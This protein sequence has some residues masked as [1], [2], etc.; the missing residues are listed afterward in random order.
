LAFR[1]ELADFFEEASSA[2]VDPPPPAQTLANWICG[3][4]VSRLPDGGSPRDC[5]ASPA[6]VAALVGLVSASR[7][8][9]GAGRTVLDRLVASGGD[10]VAIVEAEGLAAIDSSDEL[11][12]LVAAALQAHPEAAENVRAGNPKAIGPLVAH[13]MRESSGR[14]DGGAVT[15]L[16]RSQLGL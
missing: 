8:S 6:A 3:E 2:A 13:V 16:I 15:R 10:P 1:T 14:A 9:A 7:I 5:A 12:S 4:L 11:S